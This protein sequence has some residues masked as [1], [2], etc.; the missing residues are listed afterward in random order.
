M[1][2][3]NLAM[4]QGKAPPLKL[5]VIADRD[6]DAIRYAK[7]EGIDAHTI[8]YSRSAPENLQSIIK[9]TSPDL[10]ITNWHKI[11][12]E[13]TASQNKEKM[14]N[15]HYSL[16]PAFGGLIGIEPIT[17]AIERNCQFIGPTC[18]WVDAGVDTG[19]IICQSI[20]KPKL[21]IEE[22]ISTMFRLG[23]LTLLNS[24]YIVLDLPSSSPSPASINHAPSLRF[25][26]A[27]FDEVF[28]ETLAIS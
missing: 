13:K 26:E 6:C 3:V 24:L 28:W 25:N 5:Y 2:F 7:K 4:G 8:D 22:T 1:K 17:Q 9:T 27:D 16:L 20:F 11:I 15:L 19:K 18:H 12:D 23:C 21:R 14:I 10:I